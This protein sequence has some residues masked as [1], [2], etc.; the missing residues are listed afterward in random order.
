MI[1]YSIKVFSTRMK[2]KIIEFLSSFSL[3]ERALM[4]RY[5]VDPKSIYTSVRQTAEDGLGFLLFKKSNLVGL[6]TSRKLNKTVA[7]LGLLAIKPS[8]QRRGYGSFLTEYLFMVAELNGI[9]RV[10]GRISSENNK[11]I[12]FYKKLGFKKF[13]GG[14]GDY[15][16]SKSLVSTVD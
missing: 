14:D 1:D 16:I 4:S 3:Q 13:A 15:L 11:A 9:E 12:S 5:G 6:V 7:T 10:L 2:K 8:E